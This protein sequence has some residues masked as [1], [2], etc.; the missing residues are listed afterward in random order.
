MSAVAFQVLEFTPASRIDAA[1][2]SYSNWFQVAPY[3]A[4]EGS[5]VSAAAT[6]S[7]PTLDVTYETTPDRQALDPTH[8]VTAINTSVLAFTQQTTSAIVIETKSATVYTA[9]PAKLGAYGRFKFV[10][11]GTPTIGYQPTLYFIGRRG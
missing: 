1:G 8:T 2:T 3:T 5:I 11:G 4:I 10:V 7:S 6:G 9:T